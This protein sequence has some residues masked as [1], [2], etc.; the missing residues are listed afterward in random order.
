[1]PK[2]ENISLITSLFIDLNK[3]P[4]KIPYSLTLTEYERFINCKDDECILSADA[5][6][7]LME[8]VEEAVMAFV[9]RY[10]IQYSAKAKEE[11]KVL[12]DPLILAHIIPYLREHVS[13]MTMRSRFPVLFLES[14]NTNVL[15]KNY[16]EK[17]DK[18]E[19]KE[20]E[21]EVNLVHTTIKYD[22]N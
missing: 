1:M 2:I 5:T 7:N 13:N 4:K 16:Q 11:F 3:S 12:T 19:K 18:K 9:C 17:K 22:E 15:L 20:K 14:I 21:K 6:F 10:R 8:D